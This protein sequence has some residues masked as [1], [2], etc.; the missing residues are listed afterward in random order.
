MESFI[1]FA[2]GVGVIFFVV[3]ANIW[4]WRL[5]CPKCKKWFTGWP[6]YV[7]IS[8]SRR[9]EANHDFSCSNCGKRWTVRYAVRW[10][11]KKWWQDW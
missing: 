9:D 6:E 3:L 8:P 2:I 4:G 5:R 10:F 7:L 1:C 11:N